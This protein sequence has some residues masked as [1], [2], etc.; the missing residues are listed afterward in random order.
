MHTVTGITTTGL[1]WTGL[2]WTKLDWTS[3]LK[4]VFYALWYAI[5]ITL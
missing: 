4:F 3:I 1:N 5:A 2:D